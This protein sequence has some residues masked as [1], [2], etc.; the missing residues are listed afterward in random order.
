MVSI[1]GDEIAKR[2]TLQVI[3]VSKYNKV[4]VMQCAYDSKIGVR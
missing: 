3:E 2:T 4:K 1:S